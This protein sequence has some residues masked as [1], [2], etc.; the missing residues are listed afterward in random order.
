MEG[1]QTRHDQLE[2][3]L[4]NDSGRLCLEAV[5]KAAHF[6]SSPPTLPSI[7][8][9]VISEPKVRSE[10]KRDLNHNEVPMEHDLRGIKKRPKG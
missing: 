9:K 6:V 1:T 4:E 5:E 3:Q 2:L 10:S 8:F 7:R